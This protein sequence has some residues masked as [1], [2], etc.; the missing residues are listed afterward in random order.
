MMKKL[1]K[2]LAAL[3]VLLLL[4]AAGFLLLAKRGA[5]MSL[6]GTQLT[7]ATVGA[8]AV[9]GNPERD[10]YFG[11]LH[12]HTGYS[13]DANIFGNTV[14]PRQA[15]QFAKGEALE[16]SGTGI[17]QRIRSPLDFAAVTDHAQG[18]GMV[19]LCHTPGSG[20][21]WTLD[22]IGLRYKLL[23]MF[24]RIV[25]VNTQEESRHAQ[26]L[27]GPCGGDGLTCVAAAGDVWRDTRNA[28][29]EHNQ[30]GK[31]TTLIGFEYSPS[32]QLGGMFHRNVIFRD[33][34]V[35]DTVFSAADGFTEDLLRWVDTRCTG[36]CKALVIP[37]NPNFAWGMMFGDTQS[38]AK[39]SSPES[40]A[41]RVKYDRL[42][43]VFQ[44]KGSSEC[45]RGVGNTDEECGF[46]NIFPACK[47]GEDAINLKTGQHQPRCIGSNDMVRNILRKGLLE[48]KKLGSNPY[49]LGFVASTDNHNGLTG[50]TSERGYNGH[51]A[52]NDA[53][54]ELRLGQKET[55]VSKAVGYSLN[56][57]NP[58]GLTGVWA[59]QNT[60]E[61]IWDAL[62]RRESWG[63]SGTRIRLR[64]FG[65]FD[66][67]A[68]L[69]RQT[70][71]VKTAYKLGVSMGGDL[72]AAPSGGV[73]SFVVWAQ[74]DANS[75]PL[76]R[77]QIVKGWVD[78]DTTYE[79]VFDVACS[80]GLRPDGKTHRCPDNGAKVNLNDCSISQ[81]KGAAELATSWSDPDFKPSASAFY[82]VRVLENPVCRYSQYDAIKLGVT[83]P[84]S[85]PA[86]IQERAWSSPIWYS[87]K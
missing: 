6:A 23:A 38:D 40:R 29:N 53:T 65:G 54:P 82:Y 76:Q 72:N 43:E 15:Y 68:N 87:G 10:A 83:H 70:D 81:D 86:T 78:G 31:F 32:L 48:E 67:P 1:L 35:P 75:A 49:K 44:A 19:S 28:A 5:N 30:P 34:S 11:D 14:T 51:A 59:E 57:L 24:P 3:L 21:Y 58:G 69:H 36:P 16:I 26:Y 66:M 62:Y 52:P 8:L 77:L 37:H 9:Q 12:L 60:R 80:D 47:D 55:L 84:G 41:L 61:F 18:M 46:E 27:P 22:C 56:K 79:R 73:P 85:S 7:P 2:W 71:M 50:D 13:M 17:Q 33:A 74:R 25:K 42:V 64:F 20:A 39:A 63:T 4:G 45:T